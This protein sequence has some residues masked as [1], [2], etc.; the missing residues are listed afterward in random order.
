[1]ARNSKQVK[2]VLNCVPSRDTEKDWRFE[3]ALDSEVLKASGPLPKRVDLREPW[4]DIGDQGSTGSCVGWAT[5]DGVLRW[6]LVKLERLARDERLSVR[7]LWMAAK[8]SD[9]FCDRPTSFIEDE[10]TSLKSVLDIARKYGLV[11]ESV[12]P[13]GKATLYTG[14]AKT[15]YALAATRRISAYFNLGGNLRQW[16]TWLAQNGPILTRLD[17]DATWDNA[18]QVGGNLDQYQADTRRGG[19]A[20][21]IVGYAQDRFII[22]NSWGISWGEQGFGYASEAYAQ[23]AFTEAYGVSVS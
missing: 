13:F 12:V 20:V 10:G 8:E 11:R 14:D 15:F 6:H 1:M 17:V 5:A 3:Q 9:E 2:R 4:W 7:Y 22:R 21:A 19:H 18:T 16:R 23:S